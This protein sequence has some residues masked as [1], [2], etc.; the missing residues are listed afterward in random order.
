MFCNKH[1]REKS[2]NDRRI[3]LVLS[4]IRI[5]NYRHCYQIH[6]IY[7]KRHLHFVQNH[8]GNNF[9]SRLMISVRLMSSVYSLWAVHLYDPSHTHVTRVALTNRNWVTDCHMN[10]Q[11]PPPYP[12]FWID[13]KSICMIRTSE[14]S[15]YF[16]KIMYCMIRI[17]ENPLFTFLKVQH[18][19]LTVEDIVTV[20][21]DVRC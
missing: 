21:D 4:Y 15:V 13:W 20:E 7:F 1:A 2:H 17:T 9:H 14:N 12:R 18:I 5:S 16:L 3:W 19:H 6:I 10:L 11:I 8:I